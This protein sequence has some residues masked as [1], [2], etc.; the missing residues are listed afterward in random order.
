MW[1]QEVLTQKIPIQFTLGLMG[2]QGD[3]RSTDIPR[4]TG[5]L[6]DLYPILIVA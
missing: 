3:T 1:P 5:V 6:P 4:K 2:H